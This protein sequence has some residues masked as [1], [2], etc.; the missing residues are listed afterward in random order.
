MDL[1]KLFD[2]SELDQ[3][4]LGHL[5]YILNSPSFERVFRPYFERIRA[6]F[7]AVLLDPRAD[8]RAKYGDEYL[9]QGANLTTRFLDFFDKIIAETRHERAVSAREEIGQE[10]LYREAV[11]AGL[12][13]G[14]GQTSRDDGYQSDGFARVSGDHSQ[15]L[16]PEEDL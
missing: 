13:R 12:I 2:V 8:A 3:S 9:R 4:E 6:Q 10:D 7:V 1:E 5:E 16:T 14:S 15:P 11:A